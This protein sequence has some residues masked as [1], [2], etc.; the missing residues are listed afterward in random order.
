MNNYFLKLQFPPSMNTYWRH[1]GHRVLIS[2][3][4]REY[5]L[6]AIDD[7]MEQLPR[8]KVVFGR[9]KVRIDLYPP[10]RRK[11]DVDNYLKVAL[12][13]LTHANFWDD[14]SQVDDLRVVRKGIENGGRMTIL[15][16]EIEDVN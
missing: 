12:D 11:R 9:V 14:D 4:G 7:V 8:H 10:D 15:I 3:K 13:S 2:K 16:T 1:V 6:N 5:R